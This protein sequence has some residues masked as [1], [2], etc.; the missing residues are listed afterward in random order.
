MKLDLGSSSRGF[1]PF[2]Y[3]SAAIKGWVS[4]S[5]Y[6]YFFFDFL[7]SLGSASFFGCYFLGCYFLG[8][9]F[10]LLANSKS[11]VNSFWQSHVL[12]KKF[13]QVSS[14]MMLV[15]HLVRWGT[16]DLV[17]SSKSKVKGYLSWTAITISETESSLA[18]KNWFLARWASSTLRT[19]RNPF[20]A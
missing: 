3:F 15:N 6:S 18:P 8:Y 10:F 16:A 11:G 13:L 7:A 5:Y 20:L 2:F 14:S 1:L 4:S 9:S 17:A 12:P 19:S